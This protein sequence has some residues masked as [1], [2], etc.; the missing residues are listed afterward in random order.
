MAE[1]PKTPTC[2]IEWLETVELERVGDHAAQ[3]D[4]QSVPTCRHE[5]DELAHV[6]IAKAGRVWERFLQKGQILFFFNAEI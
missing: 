1:K 5:P 2:E 6:S 4:G 3:D